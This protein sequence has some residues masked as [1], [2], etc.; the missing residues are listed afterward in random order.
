MDSPTAAVI[1]IPN[2][3]II[4]SNTGALA[5]TGTITLS[6][7]TQL[8]MAGGN[9]ANTG[10]INLGGGTISGSETL[11][12]NSTGVISGYG[13]ISAPL[14]NNTGATLLVQ[15][16]TINLTHPM[17]NAGTINLV[18]PAS[19]LAGIAITNNGV[20]TGN[21][22]INNS[23]TNASSGELRA[24]P[25]QWLIIHSTASPNAGKINLQ[26]GTI[27][28]NSALSNTGTISGHAPRSVLTAD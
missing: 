10:V 20:I 11:N 17:N 8:Q 21:G 16:G 3:S 25:G 19:T 7:G 15:T 14:A 18:G 23:L 9:L 22:V 4:F 12:N 27:E 5:S 26:G 28:F 24:L 6:A 2:G 1:T 13:T